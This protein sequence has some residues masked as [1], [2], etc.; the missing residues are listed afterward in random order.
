MK[1]VACP[2]SQSK[3][4]K[5]RCGAWCHSSVPVKGSAR[6]SGSFKTKSIAMRVPS[7]LSVYR[8]GMLRF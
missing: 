6:N 4:E 3:G 7:S 8:V 1:R 2:A 5:S